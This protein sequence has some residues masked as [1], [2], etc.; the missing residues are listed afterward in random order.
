MQAW[1]LP[2]APLHA[3]VWDQVP[4]SAAPPACPLQACPGVALHGGMGV[5]G[6]EQG[7]ASIRPGDL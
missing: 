1:A 3:G 7:G 2:G 5:K 6:P 4:R